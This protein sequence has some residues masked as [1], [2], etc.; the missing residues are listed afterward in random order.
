[1]NKIR[2]YRGSPAAST[3]EI[4]LVQE[5][6]RTLGF[7]TGAID[8]L[9]GRQTMIAIKAYKKQN[10]MPVNNSLDD[11]FIAHLRHGT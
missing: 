2:P 6:M 4:M 8:G 5:T 7:Y 11:E 1:M 10:K 3:D 9:P